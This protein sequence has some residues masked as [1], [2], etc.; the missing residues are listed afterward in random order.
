MKKCQALF[1]VKQY[2]KNVLAMKK[3]EKTK[4]KKK[5]K[6]NTKQKKKTKKKTNKKKQDHK[7]V[8]G[9]STEKMFFN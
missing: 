4:Q 1:S 9:C 3:K 8:L 7:M 5:Q 6:K 2:I